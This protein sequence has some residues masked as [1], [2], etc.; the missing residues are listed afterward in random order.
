MLHFAVPC[1][2]A[3][4]LSILSTSWLLPIFMKWNVQDS[5]AQLAMLRGVNAIILLMMGVFVLARVAKPL[6]SWRGILVLAFAAIGFGG[7]LVKPVA[8]FFALVVPTGQMLAATTVAMVL[9]A[10][11]FLVCLRLVPKILSIVPYFKK[12]RQ[13]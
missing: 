12:T 3:V 8:N 13:S 10:L 11:V 1:G 7:M 4:G 5:G 9:S 6:H 2:V